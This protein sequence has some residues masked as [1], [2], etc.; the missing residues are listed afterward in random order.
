VFEVDQHRVAEGFDGYAPGVATP[1]TVPLG[2]FA[3]QRGERPVS[4]MITGRFAGSS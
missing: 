3:M 1:A 2:T 4:L